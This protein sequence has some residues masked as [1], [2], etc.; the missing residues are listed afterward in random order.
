MITT[1]TEGKDFNSTSLTATIPAGATA[2]TVRVPVMSDDIVERDEMFSMSLNVP[3]SLGPGIVAG[4]VTSATGIIV[5]STSKSFL[6]EL[7]V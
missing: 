5:D 2:T 1:I 3:S 7:Y 4:S 6:V